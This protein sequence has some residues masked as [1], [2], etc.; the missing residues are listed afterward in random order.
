MGESATPWQTFPHHLWQATAAQAVTGGPSTSRLRRSR[1]R[2][3]GSTDG[4]YGQAP[5]SASLTVSSLFSPSAKMVEAAQVRGRSI[6][7]TRGKDSAFRG[8]GDGRTDGRTADVRSAGANCC[9][10][11]PGMQHAGGCPA[12]GPVSSRGSSRGPRMGEGAPDEQAR[13]RSAEGRSG[14]G[15]GTLV[16]GEGGSIRLR[17]HRACHI[18]GAPRLGAQ[19]G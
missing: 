1:R 9:G 16:R 15:L 5:Q 7:E 14:H 4:A 11:S 12:G 3:V 17:T 2:V 13:A 19:R 10:T 8:S 6:C 18:E